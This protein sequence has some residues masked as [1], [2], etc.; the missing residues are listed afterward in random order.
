MGNAV[1]TLTEKILIKGGLYQ[2]RASIQR[3][4]AKER[5]VEI[6]RLKNEDIKVIDQISDKI[7]VL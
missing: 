1:F 3:S 5:N 4:I 2:L 6:I 7:E